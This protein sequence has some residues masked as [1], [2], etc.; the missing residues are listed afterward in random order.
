MI[1]PDGLWAPPPQAV[2]G[3]SA[4]RSGFV[5]T[6]R[7]LPSFSLPPP[8]TDPY[9]THCKMLQVLLACLAWLLEP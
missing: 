9:G 5:L 3:V 1:E 6:H 7:L 4:P 8:S 2:T